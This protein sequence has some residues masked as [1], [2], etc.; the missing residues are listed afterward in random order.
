MGVSPL[1]FLL[2]TLVLLVVLTVAQR[3]AIL[4]TAIALVVA[5]YGVFIR[6][7]SF[8]PTHTETRIPLQKT[9]FG[10][11]VSSDRS[12]LM[13]IDGM[14]YLT[15]AADTRRAVTAHCLNVALWELL[16]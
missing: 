6:S 9:V 8:V 12:G 16:P 13:S 14:R 3:L 11:C 7:Y 1:L 4:V 2:V 15:A 10:P 5:C